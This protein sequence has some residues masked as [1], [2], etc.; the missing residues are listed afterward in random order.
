MIE[1]K[2]V[3]KCQTIFLFTLLAV[4]I[5]VYGYK[6]V[7]TNTTISNLMEISSF[8]SCFIITITLAIRI[9]FKKR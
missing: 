9:S 7:P 1:D 2:Y 3:D 5:I 6:D 8:I 4:S